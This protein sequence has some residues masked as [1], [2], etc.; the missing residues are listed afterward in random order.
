MTASGT[1]NTTE[2]Q[3]T[4]SSCT[5]CTEALPLST[6]CQ[7]S[8][9]CTALAAGVRIRDLD[10]QGSGPSTPRGFARD[11]RKAAGVEDSESETEAPQVT[12]HAVLLAGGMSRQGL[13]LGTL[14][15]QLGQSS[16]R[17]RLA[18]WHTVLTAGAMQ[19]PSWLCGVYHSAAKM[20]ASGVHACPFCQK[21]LV[22]PGLVGEAHE[23]AK[24]QPVLPES[25]SAF[26]TALCPLWQ[27]GPL[28]Q[29]NHCTDTDCTMQF[30]G[31]KHSEGEAWGQA[32]LAE[33]RVYLLEG[34]IHRALMCC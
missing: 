5:W 14:L 27:P 22:L 4:A 32:W 16:S 3:E 21:L 24:G 13:C 34:K 8:I 19:Q 12:Q 20:S 1:H 2:Q 9:T 7:F 18:P 10:K 23:I 28:I 31:Q 25:P 26:G 30:V 11:Q 6:T 17:R 15:C 29:P 33:G